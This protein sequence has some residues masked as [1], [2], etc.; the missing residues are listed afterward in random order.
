VGDQVKIELLRDGRPHTVS[1]RLGELPE[2]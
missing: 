2:A 1:V